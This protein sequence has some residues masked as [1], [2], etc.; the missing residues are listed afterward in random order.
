MFHPNK[1]PLKDKDSS[2]RSNSNQVKPTNQLSAKSG[3]KLD[4][5]AQ[6]DHAMTYKMSIAEMLYMKGEMA[7]EERRMEMLRL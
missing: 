1:E 3:Q 5:Q 6:F 7:E 4:I 2:K